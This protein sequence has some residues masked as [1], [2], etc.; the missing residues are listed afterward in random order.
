M[1][2]VY[3]LAVNVVVNVGMAMRIKHRV[4][5]KALRVRCGYAEQHPVQRFTTY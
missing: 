1:A 2:V 4:P 3:K 5:L